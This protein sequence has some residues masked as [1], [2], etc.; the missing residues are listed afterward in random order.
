MVRRALFVVVAIG[1]MLMALGGC[2]TPTPQIV[3][4]EITKV[5]EKPV[6]KVVEKVVTATPV[7]VAPTVAPTAA[8]KPVAKYMFV[9]IGDGMAAAQRNSAELYLA[10]T[11]SATARPEETRLLMNTFPA[12]GMN[13]TYD[14][15]SVI[16]DSAS[17]GT[18]IASGY[19]TAS[20][21]VGMDPAGKVSY[22]TIA[23]Y[24]KKQGWKVGV[25]S[26]VS[27]DHA[28]PAAFYAHQSSRSKYYEI[29]NDMIN[30]NFDYFEGGGLLQPKG[31]KGDQT[32]VLDTAKTKGY[33]VVKTRAD[34]DKLTPASG[35]VIAINEKLQDSNAIE[36]DMDRAQGTLSLTDFTRKGIELLDNP[37]GF[38][39]MVEGGKI[40]W[41]CH[42]NDAA[43]SIRDTLALD[44]AIAEAYKFYQARPKETLIIV[45]GD[46]ETGGMTIGFAGTQYSAFFDRIQNQKMSYVAFNDKLAEFKKAKGPEAKFADIVPLIQDA[47]GLIVMSKE[48]RAALVEKAK[49]DKDAAKKLGM[50]LS[51]VEL[52]TVQ[53]AFAETIKDAKLRATDEYTYLL[54]GGYEPLTVKLTTILNQK[55]GIGW[56]S[57]SHTGVP[58]QTSAVGVNAETFNGYYDQPDIYKKMM[59]IAGF[60]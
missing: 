11:K 59:V 53:D 42:A 6:E 15:T 44:T 49:T 13:T 22:E 50:V 17:T 21:V 4:K 52:K 39:L 32:E 56:T 24:A 35:K 30:S 38:F 40:D 8:P 33:A 57:Y 29:A 10:A 5:V 58:V 9:F 28:T 14:L 20:G 34:F 12:Q 16:P 25:V 54:Y 46:H 19:K 36:Y 43:A 55:A 31:A 27:L 47:F 23:E 3:E 26:S 48:D 41:S 7:P 2:A 45:T 1:I 60:K 51:D 18:A 37:K